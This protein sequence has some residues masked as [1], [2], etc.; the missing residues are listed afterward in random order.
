MPNTQ[1]VV[2]PSV[3]LLDSFADAIEGKTQVANPR[4]DGQVDQV[5]L[6]SGGEK[7]SPRKVEVTGKSP[8][9]ADHRENSP[10]CHGSALPK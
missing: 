8:Q 1:T 4:R 3:A 5:W 2:T 9:A 7:T 10:R 6:S